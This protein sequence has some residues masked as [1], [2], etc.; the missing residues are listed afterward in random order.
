MTGYGYAAIIEIDIIRSMLKVQNLFLYTR[1]VTGLLYGDA[2]RVTE[3]IKLA[4]VLDVDSEWAC[5]LPE[6]KALNRVSIL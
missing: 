5:K 3:T 2:L 4:F 1:L 6:S